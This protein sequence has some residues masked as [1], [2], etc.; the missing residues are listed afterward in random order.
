MARE[1][2]DM[3]E[4]SPNQGILYYQL[5]KKFQPGPDSTV[6]NAYR[7]AVREILKTPGALDEPNRHHTI[8][9]LTLLAGEYGEARAATKT[10]ILMFDKE[11]GAE[12][13]GGNF[14]KITTDKGG[15]DHRRLL[16][17]GPFTINTVIKFDQAFMI[18]GSFADDAFRHTVKDTVSLLAVQLRSSREANNILSQFLHRLIAEAKKAGKYEV[19]HSPIFIEGDI[20]CVGVEMQNMDVGKNLRL[21]REFY[22]I[23][24]NQHAFLSAMACAL[25]AP[26]SYEI[27]K[28]APVGYL[29][30]THVSFGR[31]GGAKTSIDAIFV[32]TGYNQEKAQGMLVNEQVVTPF[33]F[34]KNLGESILP[35]IINDVSPDWMDKM[36][37]VLKN[38]AE[39]SIAGDRG[40]PDQTITEREVRRFMFI[41]LNDII[42]PSDDSAKYRRYVLEQYTEQHETRQNK[43]EYRKFMKSIDPGFMFGIFR[44]IYGGKRIQDVVSDVAQNDD[45]GQ[46]VNA[47]LQKVN[48]L[49]GKYMV[50]PFP[51]YT[52][53]IQGESYDDEFTS[54]IEYVID[55]WARNR[56][57]NDYARVKGPF[58]DLSTYE[59]DVD[60]KDD[61]TVILWF[62]GGAYRKVARKIDLKH[63]TA[64][65]LFSNYVKNN[66]YGIH[67]VNK[68]HRFNREVG[69]GFALWYRRAKYEQ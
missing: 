20:V 3:S 43:P 59:I 61:E 39:N 65:R 47:M 14:Y 32:I 16:L 10:I 48:I 34:Q 38:A 5:E 40:N 57:T 6:A 45:A 26:L 25:I 44:E 64:T 69:R 66:S 8:S 9:Q 55:Q 24:T 30:P 52:Y 27:R 33:I 2:V 35:V 18:E 29:L 46:F 62:T 28:R 42:N 1:Q 11:T 54:F 23:A 49:C 31:T 13:Q 17:S 19:T 37:T 50:E 53:E 21:L 56:N 15:K 12:L 41:T 4:Q 36:S 51:D 67:S 68:S 22:N 58:A 63:L 60:D 7:A